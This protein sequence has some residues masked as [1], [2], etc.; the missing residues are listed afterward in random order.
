MPD[1]QATISTIRTDEALMAI[2]GYVAINGQQ[3]SLS[4]GAAQ[5]GPYLKVEIG[6]PLPPPRRPFPRACACISEIQP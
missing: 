1:T 2:A 4:V 6:K 5:I 3:E